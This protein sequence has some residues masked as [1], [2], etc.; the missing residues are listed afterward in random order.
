MNKDNVFEPYYCC[1]STFSISNTEKARFGE[2][3]FAEALSD[4]PVYVNIT[5]GKRQKDIDHLVLT[6]NSLIMNECK[7]T[8]E[9]FHMYYSWFLSHVV[10]RFADGLPVAQY[11]ARSFGYPTRCVKFTLTIPCLNT[12]PIVEKA[13]RGLEIHVIQTGV[14]IIREQD[15]KL[16]YPT[17]REH[18]LSVINTRYYIIRDLYIAHQRLSSLSE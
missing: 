13:I 16:W 8:K 15:K 2:S 17:V 4:F 11:Y 10:D 7:N 18:I 9:D 3:A 6:S 1:V 5:Y 12:E 14:Q